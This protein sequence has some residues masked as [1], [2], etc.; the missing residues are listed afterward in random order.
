ML[1]RETSREAWAGFQ[2]LS[3]KLDDQ[4]LAA[5]K[6]VGRATCQEIEEAIGRD[7][8]S[9]SG[10]LRHLVEDGKVRASGEFGKT[11]SGRR[12]IRWELVPQPAEAV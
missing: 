2:P 6:H 11:R 8:Q 5:L 1:Y 9:V 10:N 3:P 12:A 7:H 4:I